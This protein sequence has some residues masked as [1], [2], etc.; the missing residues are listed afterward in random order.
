MEDTAG[1][2]PGEARTELPAGFDAQLYF[3]GRIRTPWPTRADCPHRGDAEAGPVCRIE[4][5]PRWQPA[6]AG[7]APGQR[8]QIL[9]WLDESRRDLVTQRSHRADG[10]RGTF[11]LR[12]PVRPNPIASSEVVL[13]ALD[14]PVLGVRGL[15]CRDGTPLLDIKP[16]FRDR[17]AA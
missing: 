16:V 12:S 10:P 1:I 9:Y 14:G 3:I 7:L 17:P 15:D 2:R 11:A 8:L 5:D 4:L 6:L 13:V